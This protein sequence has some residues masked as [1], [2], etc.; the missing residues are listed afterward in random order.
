MMIVETTLMKIAVVSIQKYNLK[1]ILK[2][3]K[4]PHPFPK[5]LI[6]LIILKVKEGMTLIRMYELEHLNRF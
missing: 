2:K 1:K 5:K 4:P 6:H 3:P